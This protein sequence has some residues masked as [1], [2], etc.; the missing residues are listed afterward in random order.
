VGGRGGGCWGVR[1]FRRGRLRG[2]GDAGCVRASQGPLGRLARA[3]SRQACLKGGGS[4][5][6]AGQ[7]AR[8]ATVVHCGWQAAAAQAGE[9]PASATHAHASPRNPPPLRTIAAAAAL[10]L[11]VALAGPLAL[12]LL[13]LVGRPGRGR[14]DLPPDARVMPREVEPHD[15]LR[16]REEARGRRAC[17]QCVRARVCVFWGRARERA[18][19]SARA[20][21]AGVSHRSPH[22][23]PHT[24]RAARRRQRTAH[25]VPTPRHDRRAAT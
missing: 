15:R 2:T 3:R 21:E 16:A 24:C 13:A 10:H 23:T 19:E 14:G 6:A 18:S 12:K 9:P 11:V 7:G 22:T 4:S 5:E 17:A 25:S 1:V 8:H 20:S